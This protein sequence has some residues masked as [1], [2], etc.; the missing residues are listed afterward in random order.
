MLMIFFNIYAMLQADDSDDTISHVKYES[1]IITCS[2]TKKIT[3][4][5]R[6]AYKNYAAINNRSNI[7]TS[8]CQASRQ[9][10]K[11]HKFFLRVSH[12][13]N[14]LKIY[15]CVGNIGN[16]SFALLNRLIIGKIIFHASF[17]LRIIIIW[18][19]VILNILER[20]Y[21]IIKITS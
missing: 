19:H 12:K 15:I 1:T 6:D 20:L 18:S 5:R 14:R 11:I 17:F 7:S 13:I 9:N 8:E 3:W 4:V 16:T 10:V 2:L 21:I